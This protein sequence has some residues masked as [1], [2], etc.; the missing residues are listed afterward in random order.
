VNLLL[1][2]VEP[3]DKFDLKISQY[4]N[5]EAIALVYIYAAILILFIYDS[6]ND[7]KSQEEEDAFSLNEWIK[8]M[9]TCLMNLKKEI[10]GW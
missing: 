1:Q 4:E 7:Q 10:S 5:I 8:E 3:I 9:Q 2:K 6:N